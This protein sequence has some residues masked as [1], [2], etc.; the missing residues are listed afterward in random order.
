M[1]ELYCLGT[2]RRR[3]FKGMVSEQYIYR[4]RHLSLATYFFHTVRRQGGGRW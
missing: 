2:S 1:I 4:V 3:V